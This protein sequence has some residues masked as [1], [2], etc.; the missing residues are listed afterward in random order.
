MTWVN[1]KVE[2]KLRWRKQCKLAV[3]VNND[4][5]DNPVGITFTIKDT[6]LYLP[7]IILSAKVNEKLS[8][9]L[10]KGFERSGYW[11]EYKI[12]K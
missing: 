5:N 9:L 2:L 6:K 8:K 12:K 10:S 3:T 1:C 11:N 7:V 4:T